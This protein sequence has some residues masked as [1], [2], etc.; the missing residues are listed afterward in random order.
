[1]LMFS[2]AATT[3]TGSMHIYTAHKSNYTAL[4]MRDADEMNWA[5]DRPDNCCTV[6][7]S[8]E[9]PKVFVLDMQSAGHRH[10]CTRRAD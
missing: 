1:M 4:V 7:S 2:E 8:P 5:R 3:S 6:T 9:S 10:E